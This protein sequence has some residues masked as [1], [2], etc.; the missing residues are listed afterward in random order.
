MVTSNLD[1]FSFS[2]TNVG[3]VS[4]TS[5]AYL[6]G[7]TGEHSSTTMYTYKDLI[8]KHTANLVGLGRTPQVIKNHLT[9]LHSFLRAAGK[10]EN[11][12][13]GLEFGSDFDR[14]V[15]KAI[16]Q[17]KLGYKSERD[18]R[19]LLGLWRETCNAI[20][21]GGPI[22]KKAPRRMRRIS[23][24]V[25]NMSEFEIELKR[26]IADSGIKAKELARMAGISTSAISRWNRGAVPNASTLSQV[27]R[28]E[29]AMN[30]DAGR[31]ASLLRTPEQFID[32]SNPNPYRDNY[33]NIREDFYALKIPEFT[34]GLKRE[35]LDFLEYKT[36]TV[37][38][39]LKRQQTSRWNIEDAKHSTIKPHELLLVGNGQLVP[40]ASLVLNYV[41]RFLGFLSFDKTRGGLGLDPSTTQTLAW[42]S[43]P[44]AVEAFLRFMTSR[45]EG[46]KH[47]SH[48]NFCGIVIAMNREVYGYLRQQ[49]DVM[50]RLPESVSQGRS[51]EQMCARSLEVA[52]QWKAESGDTWRDP[53]LSIKY[54]LDQ[55]SPLAPVLDA[56]FRIKALSKRAPPRSL[57]YALLVRDA[58]ILALFVSN[59][60][61]CK[62]MVNLT[63]TPGRGGQVHRA[64]G[65]GWRIRI[66]GNLF[67]NRKRVRNQ[68]YTVPVAGWVVPLL[69]EY[70]EIARP[71]LMQGKAEHGYLL[72]TKFGKKY[73]NLG[74]HVFTLT[75]RYIP[76]CGG[77]GP[78]AFRHLV[79]TDWLTQFPNDY[80]TVAELLNDTL[81]VV[82]KNYAHLKKDVA[83][84]RY[85]EYVLGVLN[86][87][88]RG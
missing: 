69:E 56:I 16:L 70:V 23:A 9:A 80:V 68:T 33:K 65:S 22:P 34:D 61:R 67:K 35:W 44:S 32:E 20:Q 66:P 47:G 2:I 55:P 11:S 86:S 7:G 59:P 81:E 6:T 39:L 24:P 75:Q 28:L 88:K 8:R 78:H 60:L 14:L 42:L 58:L 15:G 21:T 36:A 3:V 4:Q 72:T 64:G 41:R 43:V 26:V 76:E 46:H 37:P 10:D 73:V 12:R 17:S 50:A 18:R 27:A 71:I 40:T 87:R 25:E 74:A 13:I 48:R 79:A 52:R 53:G 19:Y 63:Y 85:E 77:I 38:E 30:L 83:F 45:S 1:Q 57:E 82:L 5:A 31:L 62:N 54:F 84:A 49:P 51:W 29:Q